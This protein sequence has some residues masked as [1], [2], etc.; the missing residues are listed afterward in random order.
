MRD[1]IGSSNAGA[2]GV[3][4]GGGGGSTHRSSCVERLESRIG[5]GCSLK[6]IREQH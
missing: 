6:A 1:H 3:E 5:F 4:S 2:T